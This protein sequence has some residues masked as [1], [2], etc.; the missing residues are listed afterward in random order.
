NIPDPCPPYVNPLPGTAP[1]LG[2]YVVTFDAFASSIRYATGLNCAGEEGTFS[3]AIT[4]LANVTYVVGQ[5][6]CPT[7]PVVDGLQPFLASPTDGIVV[8][9]THETPASAVSFESV[10]YVESEGTPQAVIA[11]RRIGNLSGGASVTLNTSNGTALA[12][13]DYVT[14]QSPVL[15]GDGV[16]GAFGNVPLIND[17]VAE[18]FE[19]VNM[20]LTNPVNTQIGSIG[21]AFL[22]ID[23]DDGLTRSMTIRDSVNFTGPSTWSIV[24][25][26]PWVSLSATSGSGPATVSV[27]VAPG[28]KPPGTYSEYFVVNGDSTE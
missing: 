25:N 24:N 17:N 18:P 9:I 22:W 15:F 14:T 5:T 19:Y 16:D 7:F 23:D 2:A 1:G 20:A 26:I 11:L 3:K 6:T 28:T 10:T 13:Q 21:S 4:A 12:G 8:A 27:T